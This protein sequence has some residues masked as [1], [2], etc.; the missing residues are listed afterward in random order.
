MLLL[1]SAGL[2]TLVEVGVHSESIFGRVVLTLTALYFS[3]LLRAIVAD[4]DVP[5]RVTIHFH[6]EVARLLAAYLQLLRLPL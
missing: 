6:I 4:R 2:G 1:N 3:W 5:T